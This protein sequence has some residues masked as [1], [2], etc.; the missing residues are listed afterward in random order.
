MTNVALGKKLRQL[1][2]ERGLSQHDLCAILGVKDRQTVSAVETGS[3]R[4]SAQELLRVIEQLGVSLDFFNDPFQ[5]VGE[6]EFSWRC[7]SHAK[8]NLR[9][10]ELSARTWI[11][12][13]RTLA[14]QVGHKPSFIRA[15]L[16]ITTESTCEDA[17]EAGEQFVQRFELGEYPSFQLVQS[18]EQDLDILVLMIETLEGISSATCRLPDLTTVLVSRNEST[19]Q[20]SLEL[21][22]QLFH[23]L[24]WDSISPNHIV[25]P[26]EYG[27]RQA[28]R[29]SNS[30]VG[31]LLMPV[32]TLQRYKGWSVLT[33]DELKSRISSVASEFQVTSPALVWRLVALGHLK[34][35][36]A[37][38]LSPSIGDA[39]VRNST[40]HM[41]PR[42][43]SNRFV[44]L[45]G[46]AMDSGVISAR[47]AASLLNMTLE[48]LDE[49]FVDHELSYRVAL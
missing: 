48:D 17:M 29:L 49:L 18:M 34:Q 19:H 25:E 37:R 30:F 2:I 21:A 40:T 3:R 35:S 16:G 15:S 24:T 27:G 42:L 5:L 41:R 45:L 32:E 20:R 1:R 31:A 26:Q 33:V 10:C 8:H 46:K 44:D 23:L 28:Q 47:R 22:N 13:Y 6:G 38:R 9:E 39:G 4:L 14:G 36:V 11:A 12:I 7:Q 43:F